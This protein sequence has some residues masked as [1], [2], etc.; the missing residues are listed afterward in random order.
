MPYPSYKGAASYSLSLTRGFGNALFLYFL[1][2][3]GSVEEK[4]LIL[5]GVGSY[6]FSFTIF[7]F[8][9]KFRL[10]FPLLRFRLADSE[11][12]YTFTLLPGC[13]ELD[14]EYYALWPVCNFWLIFWMRSRFWC[15]YSGF[16]LLFT[17]VKVWFSF[18]CRLLIIYKYDDG[19]DE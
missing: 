15:C 16:D 10:F 13:F 2:K 14:I 6:R 1:L 17:F 12:K 7:A 3:F 8:F 19:C 9:L 4:L 11:Y 18:Y 5:I